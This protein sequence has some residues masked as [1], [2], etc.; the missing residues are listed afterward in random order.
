M[1][2]TAKCIVLQHAPPDADQMCHFLAEMSRK[3]GLLPR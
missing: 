2:G 3:V 1:V